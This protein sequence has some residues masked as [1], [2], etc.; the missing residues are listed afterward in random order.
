[1]GIP[2]GSTTLT[3]CISD[4]QGSPAMKDYMVYFQGKEYL[5]T[6][7]KAHNEVGKVSSFKG[8]AGHV[9]SNRTKATLEVELMRHTD[10]ETAGLTEQMEKL[11]SL[12]RSNP[13]L[14][15]QY[16]RWENAKILVDL[17]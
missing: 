3:T 12:V 11:R 5:C 9:H 17:L 7:V 2:S 6:S 1:M 15:E 4:I 16:E 8:T 13:D 14:N 10:K